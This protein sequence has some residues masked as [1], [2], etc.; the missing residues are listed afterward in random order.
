VYEN[1]YDDTGCVQGTPASYPQ[2]MTE[3]LSFWLVLCSR[4]FCPVWYSYTSLYSDSH[5]SNGHHFDKTGQH[6]CHRIN[7]YPNHKHSGCLNSDCH[8]YDTDTTAVDR[9]TPILIDV[10]PY[11]VMKAYMLG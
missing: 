2:S 7:P 5:F 10:E 1:Y 8:S 9:R 3:G 6:A 4:V 11:N